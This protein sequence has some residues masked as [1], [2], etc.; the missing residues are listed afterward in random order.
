MDLPLSD[1]V[2]MTY[3]LFERQFQAVVIRSDRADFHHNRC[4]N[5]GARCPRMGGPDNGGGNLYAY[6]NLIEF[7]QEDSIHFAAKFGQFLAVENVY[8]PRTDTLRQA[9]ACGGP[10][11][12][13]KK[14]ANLVV[15]KTDVGACLE[16]RQPYVQ[17]GAPSVNFYTSCVASPPIPASVNLETA[18]DALAN[19]LRNNA[20]PQAYVVD[21]ACR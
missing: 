16:H 12:T 10:S 20:R 15:G 21:N 19:A 3:N 2:T 7:W 13:W 4:L 6:N 11:D 5:S 17:S 14:T 1:L 8:N 18:S 9:G